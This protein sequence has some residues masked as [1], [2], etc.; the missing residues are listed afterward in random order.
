[1]IYYLTGPYHNYCFLPGHSTVTI[2]HGQ[3]LLFVTGV[4]PTVTILPRQILLLLYFTMPY[5]TAFY[6][7][8]P[9]SYCI[10]PGQ[11][12]LFL[13]GAYI[14]YCYCL[15]VADPAVTI[16]LRQTRLLHAGPDPTV[17]VSYLDRPHC[18]LPGHTYSTVTVWQWQT[19]LLLYY[20]DR[21]IC[22]MLGQ[23][24][25]LL[26]YRDRPYRF[27]PGQTLLLS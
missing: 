8:R 17:T 16:L 20:W 23:T 11:T 2:L 12:S 9:Y 13:T 27:L 22:F 10:L 6:R 24:R 21:P 18:F 19:L 26:S 3:T 1:M 14:L 15:T 25:Q 5:L 4:Y 7:D